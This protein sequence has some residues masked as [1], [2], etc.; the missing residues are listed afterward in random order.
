MSAKVIDKDAVGNEQ[1]FERVSSL[2]KELKERGARIAVEQEAYDNARKQL[3]SFSATQFFTDLDKKVPELVTNHE[4]HTDDG[5]VNINFRMVSKPMNEIN[6][7]PASEVLKKVAGD[8]NYGK[9]FTEEEEK[10]PAVE[11]PEMLAQAMAKPDLFALRLRS[12]TPDQQKVLVSEHP[13]WVEV[14]IKDVEEYSKHFP[15]SINAKVF[16]KPTSNFIDACAALSNEA[17]VAIRGF[18]KTYLTTALQP[19]LSTGNSAKTS[20][21]K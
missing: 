2:A 19:A 3:V 17:K 20:K 18:L 10:V 16:V 6:K 8:E 1:E 21:K 13:E 5:I 4:Y 9:I 11:Y 15:G 12:L 14:S 7:Q